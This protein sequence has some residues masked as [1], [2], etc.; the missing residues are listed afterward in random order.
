MGE[1]EQARNLN[2][3]TLNL[4]DLEVTSIRLFRPVDTGPPSY[5]LDLTIDIRPG[6]LAPDSPSQN[7]RF[8]FYECIEF[9]AAI[10]I[11]MWTMLGPELGTGRAV[12]SAAHS[13]FTRYT[14]ELRPPSGSLEIVARSF[15]YEG[16]ELD[17]VPESERNITP[18]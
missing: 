5:D 7:A 10:D 12:T 9:G 17:N 8:R 13:E 6:T 4:W 14:L 3:N 18:G 2:L 15:S 16:P 1:K 11:R